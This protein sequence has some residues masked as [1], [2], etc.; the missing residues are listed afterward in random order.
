MSNIPSI[1]S[2]FS[3]PWKYILNESFTTAIGNGFSFKWKR[4]SFIH[5]FVQTIIAIRRRP[6]FLKNLVSAGRNRL[7]YFF[8]DT[9]S[10]GSSFLV[11][12]FSINYKLCASIRSFFLLVDTILQI[13]CKPILFHF[14][15]SWQRKQFSR[16]VET[17]FLSKCSSRRVETD[18]LLSVRLFRANFVLVE[19]II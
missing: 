14:F 3:I 18:F 2:S 13:R 16:L 15:Y 1:E 8:S 12:W 6:I 4:C 9:D 17:N 7:L 19:T 11:Q 10:N 5:I